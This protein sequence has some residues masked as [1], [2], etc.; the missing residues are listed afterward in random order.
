MTVKTRK[1]YLC[2]SGV[3]EILYAQ[4]IGVEQGYVF[5]NCYWFILG[6]MFV[7][8]N[9]YYGYIVYT[10]YLLVYLK[11]KLMALQIFIGKK[12]LYYI[13]IFDLML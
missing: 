12:I 3:Y 6:I 4:I 9:N 7:T 10:V 13:W 8:D 1:S 11:W 2:Q 5:I